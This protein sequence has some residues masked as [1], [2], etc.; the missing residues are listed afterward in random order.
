MSLYIAANMNMFLNLIHLLSYLHFG[1][2]GKTIISLKRS[3]S[4]HSVIISYIA[5]RIP[6]K[7]EMMNWDRNWMTMK[8][9]STMKHQTGSSAST[10][11]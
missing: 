9:I 11:R 8:N 6:V 7:L 10:K 5:I 3:M 1:K 4:L 2:Y